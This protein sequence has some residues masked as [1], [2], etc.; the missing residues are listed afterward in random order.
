MLDPVLGSITLQMDEKHCDCSGRPSQIY[1][2]PTEFTGNNGDKML[3]RLT[4]SSS[5][6]RLRGN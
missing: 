5:S 6:P 4:F 1:R 3:A 2:V